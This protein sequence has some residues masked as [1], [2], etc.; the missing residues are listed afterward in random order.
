MDILKRNCNGDASETAI[1]RFMECVSPVVAEYRERYPKQAE[2]PFSSVYKY[3]Y[4][5]HQ[6]TDGDAAFFVVM[7]GAPERIIN[8]CS[9]TIDGWSFDTRMMNSDL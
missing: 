3:Q 4:S 1:L 5:V 9:H 6:N 7:K 8:V 2:K